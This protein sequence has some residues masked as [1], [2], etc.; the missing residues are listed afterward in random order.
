[1]FQKIH[2]DNYL[3][4]CYDAIEIKCMEHL[5]QCFMQLCTQ[6]R[7]MGGTKNV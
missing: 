3:S 7:F 4:F 6:F 5:T 1:M 2:L